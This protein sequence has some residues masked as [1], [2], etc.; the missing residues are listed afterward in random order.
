VAYALFYVK[1][2]TWI[3]GMFG[4]VWSSLPPPSLGSCFN[5][6]QTTTRSTSTT[7]L[8]VN[9]AH[10]ILTNS[11]DK[12]QLSIIDPDSFPLFRPHVQQKAPLPH[13]EGERLTSIVSNSCR[14]E[15]RNRTTH[16]SF[17]KG[18]VMKTPGHE[19]KTIPVHASLRDSSSVAHASDIARVIND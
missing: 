8:I 15:V 16:R 6:I 13:A 5:L 1:V 10:R 3:P 11:F 19:K 9:S 7:F 18:S 4:Y 2:K 17:V 14:R 12:L